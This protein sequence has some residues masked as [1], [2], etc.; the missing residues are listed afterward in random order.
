MELAMRRGHITN[1]EFAD[2]FDQYE[3]VLA[4][5]VLFENSK[6]LWGAKSVVIA[7]L[8]MLAASILLLYRLHRSHRFHR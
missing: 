7:G 8:A 1:E 4:Q 5:L 2:I 3:K 6:Y